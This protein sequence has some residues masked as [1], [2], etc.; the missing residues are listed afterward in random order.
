L[1]QTVLSELGSVNL[2]GCKGE[3]EM[4]HG[5]AV[6]AWVRFGTACGHHPLCQSRDCTFFGPN[7]SWNSTNFHA[8]Q[9][10]TDLEETGN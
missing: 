5:S 8:A 7:Q 4:L 6:P 10:Q 3:D 2:T 1:D 9:T